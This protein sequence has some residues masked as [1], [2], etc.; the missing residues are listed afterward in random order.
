MAVAGRDCT[1]IAK[2][3]HYASV[4]P[5]SADL[6]VMERVE[7]GDVAIAYDDP[8]SLETYLLVMRNVLLI[9]SMDHNLL[10]PFLVREASLFLDETPKFQS[11]D[12]S[13]ENHT[14]Y[15]EVTGLRIHLQL[16]GTFSYFVS[17][18]LTLEEQ[19]HWENYPVVHLT[20]D[21]DQWDPHALHFAEAEA[22]MLDSSGE[23]V[24]QRKRNRNLFEEA[25][26]SVLYAEPC[27]WDSLE[28]L[29]DNQLSDVYDLSDPL[30]ED[31]EVML[32]CDGIRAQIASLNTVFEPP[33][34]S[35]VLIDQALISK[36]SMAMGSMT[37]D[38]AACGVFEARVFSS[39]SAIAAGR[40]KG[41][42]AEHLVKIWRI[43][44]DDAARTLEVTTQ[45]IR[46]D[47]DSSLSRN[48]RTNDRA[49]RYRRISSKFFTD[50]LFATK[51]AKS[52]RGNTCAQIFV[53]D[54]D[55]IA[56]YPMKKEAEY[57]LALKEFSKDVGAPDVLVCDSA[58]T[59][60]KREVKDFCT[61]IGTTLNILEAETQWANR[62]ELWVGLVKESTRKDLRDSGSPIVLWDYCME[63]RVLIYQVTAKK[64]FQLH[65]MNPHTATFGTQADISNLC[66]FGWYEWVYYRE[67]QAPY[68]FQKE[69]LG[70]CLG[71]AKNEGNVMANWILT[72]KGTVIPRRSIRR[73]TADERSDSN[74][75]EAQKRVSF[76]ADITAKLGDS[77]KLPS[78]P[79]P[80]WVEPDWD[81]EPYGD[82]TTSEHEPFEADLVDAAGKPILMHSLT[83]VLINAEV[84]LS[85]DDSTAL[86]RVIRRA[87][88]SNGKVIGEW[89]SNPILNTL[90]YECE[91]NDGTIK[92]YSANVIA[93]NIYEEGDADGFSSSLLYKIVDHKSSGEAIKMADKYITTR[94]GTR[95]MRQT[96]VGWSF[97]VKWG[98]GSQQW[99][100]LKI[101]KESNPV[102]VGAYVIARGIQDEPAFAWWVP[103]VM[104]KRDIIVSMVK[105]R[106]RRTTHKYGIEM[107]APGREIVQNAIDLDRKNGD[108]FWMDSLAKEMRNLNIAFEYLELG[109][110]A[111]PG[112]FKAT[113]HIVFDVKMDFTRKA[114]WVK[115]GHKTPDSTT[116]SFAGV[117]SRE[118]IRIG[119]T[120]AALLG[121]PVIGG[122]IQN[123]Y[124]Q[125]P[126]S[127]KHFIVC[128][129]EFGTENVGRVALIR[130]AL[131]G[132]KVAGRD[133][134]HHLRECMG[135]LGFTSSR[136]D[137]DVWFRLSK[138]STGEEYYEYVLLY[139]DDVLVISEKAE[140]VL[141]KEIGKDWVLKEDSIG[142]PSKYLGGKLREVT[143]TSGVKCWAF[144]SCQYV[145]SAVNNVVDHLKKKGLKLPHKAPNPLSTEYRPE[146]DVTPE[147]GEAD[148]SYYHTLIGVLRWIVELGR[149]DIDVE[150]SM[151]SSHLALPREGHLKELYHI[152]AY[153]KAR[154]N[155]EMVFDPTPIE[156]DKTLF[157]RQDWSYSAYGYESLKEELPSDMPVPH[158]QSMTMR[159]FVDADHAGDQVT[160]RSRTGFIV[161][162]N[163]API[164]WSSK[165]Q[166]SCETSTFGSE[167]VA[168]KQAT[169]YVR[170]LR[171]KLRM[172]GI[173]VDEPAFVFGDNQSVLCNTTAPAS[174]LKKKSNA[175]AY[176]FVRE[177]VARDEWRTAYVNTDENLADLL[178][179]PLSG[180]KRAK[181]VRMVLHHVFP[182]KGNGDM[183]GD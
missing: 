139:V 89:D 48:A 97:L 75:V 87:V 17:R 113:G 110:K 146:T 168:M 35:A 6:P 20:P 156:P 42:T 32:T 143:L 164:Y 64:L 158:G 127:E 73:L 176:H 101:L 155:A 116:S 55:F 13:L 47:P 83:D 112:W 170:G 160:R 7:I 117:V 151:M 40:S 161:F 174:T 3:G 125:A 67:Q 49:V 122:D 126:S 178:T 107:P 102:Q 81:S 30:S 82:D 39:L 118:S 33:I 130:R 53:S 16:N 108:T 4:T 37:V 148:A 163:N 60:K 18:S 74:E 94:T 15:D 96:T 50:T 69:C 98:D 70:R 152:F 95:R 80:D 119:L 88:D 77:V 21:S 26:I 1:I 65:G 179:K 134:W 175:I 79:L 76:N 180:P 10:P 129:P 135:R 14:I 121:L 91:F 31:D 57:F 181:F 147:L 169:E 149:I 71:P 68:P 38:D 123:A 22:A 150:V 111:P 153:L 138:R 99:I 61:Q 86:A 5:F 92:E 51:M 34:F 171:Y 142:P 62:S 154:S 105:S 52:L 173:K 44:Y 128:G 100:D 36:V 140:A 46:Q 59:Q 141:R 137:P 11:T 177:G 25:D 63:R 43:P 72:Q 8:Y 120:Y 145:H 159:V 106:V 162:L 84:L 19:E 54:K 165:K 115:D 133:F 136:A 183:G 144:G 157:E 104:R 27:T 93:S 45:R 78:N 66:L 24:G 90:V 9:P 56:L 23:I 12:V 166:T 2:S 114:R 132:G 182:E 28:E 109:E 167:F 85:K 124:L 41:V 131:Y 103:Y 172:M 58:K 29:I